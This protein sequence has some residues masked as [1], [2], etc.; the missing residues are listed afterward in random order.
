M[1]AVS[2]FEVEIGTS[3]GG[4]LPGM[5][6]QDQRQPSLLRNTIHMKF[7]AHMGHVGIFFEISVT[8]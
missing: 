5:V 4:V 8:A 3:V 6:Y 7:F 2:C 1:R